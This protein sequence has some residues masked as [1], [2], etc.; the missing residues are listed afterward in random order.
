M[1]IPADLDGLSEEAAA[2][3]ALAVEQLEELIE[4]IEARRVA[5]LVVRT[6][7]DYALEDADPLWAVTVEPA[8]APPPQFLYCLPGSERMH[9]DPQGVAAEYI[10]PPP[11][12]VVEQWTVCPP[13]SLLPPPGVVLDD[14]IDHDE[15][16]EGLHEAYLAALADG[17][18]EALIAQALDLLAASVRYWMADRL[19]GTVRVV[20]DEADQ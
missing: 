5:S 13:R 15:G 1:R 14:I 20:L 11:F 9:L 12:A 19:V 10:D 4:R 2:A 6:E 18:V 17:K 8:G 7:A 16:D 3:R